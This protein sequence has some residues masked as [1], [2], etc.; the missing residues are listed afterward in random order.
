[1][2][3]GLNSCKT[4]NSFYTELN[5]EWVNEKIIIPVEIEGKMYRF[6]LD[7]GAP[8]IISNGLKNNI[9]SVFLQKLNISDA[10]NKKGSMVLEKIP[11]LE[12]GG[13]RYK[14]VPCLIA[15]DQTEKLL[16]CFHAEGFIGSNLLKKSI[17]QILPKEKKIKLT[18]K[19]RRLSLD[20][21]KSVKMKFPDRQKTPYFW[22][23]YGGK[24]TANE[25]IYLDTGMEGFFDL[26]RKHF[27]YFR[28]HDVF[29]V[30]SEGSG[31]SSI[32]VFGVEDS[33]MQYKVAIPELLIG[34]TV[35]RNVTAETTDN[36]NSRIG[37]RILDYG[38]ITVDYIHGRLYFEP[39]ENPVDV[40]EKTFG[41]D[42]IYRNGKV[43]VGI[44]WDKA[45]KEKI[46]TGDRILMINEVDMRNFS[47][48]DYIDF[49]LKKYEH[50]KMTVVNTKG[51]KTELTLDKIYK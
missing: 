31:S 23:H 29:D 21:R 8:V 25:E 9:S 18:D 16:D 34:K 17:I 51:K 48:C 11:L 42:A 15:N 20:K 50:I 6:I 45:L 10:N 37:S 35:L 49:N 28:K 38:N 41:F 27:N 22:V 47:L 36:A 2:A 4:Q 26:C 32:G 19:K 24:E 40:N 33:T 44:V 14:N 43:I 30:V 7:T 13:V 39:F 46:K 12:I 1:M 3:Q 5:Y